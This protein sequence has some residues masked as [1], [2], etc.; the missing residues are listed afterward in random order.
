M[1]L[2]QRYKKCIKKVT[3]AM[4][5]NSHLVRA[6]KAVTEQA[7]IELV[8]ERVENAKAPQSKG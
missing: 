6:W 8:N 5:K 3:K 1:N 7:R 4:A 2:E